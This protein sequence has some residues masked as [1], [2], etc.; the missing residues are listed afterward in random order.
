MTVIENYIMKFLKEIS[1]CLEGS[2][3]LMNIN[4]LFNV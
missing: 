2:N 3:V 1:N 4:R